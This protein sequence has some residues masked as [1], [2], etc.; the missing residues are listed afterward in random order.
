[1]TQ[2]AVKASSSSETRERILDAAELLFIER[3]FAATSLR[4]IASGAGVNLAAT[5]YH[6]GSKNGLL[7]AVFHRRIAPINEQR[8]SEFKQL[9]ETDPDLTIRKVVEV[10]FR[11]FMKSDLYAAIPA[12]IGRIYGEP[13]AIT[14]PLLESEFAEV[15]GVFHA[16][17]TTVLPRVSSKELQWRTH[18]MIGSLIHLLRLNSPLGVEPSRTSFIEGLEHLIN[19]SIAGLE[20][21]SGGNHDD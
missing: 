18:F 21:A 4:A 12:L 20:Q 1:M 13:E 3:G 10:F 19:F 11:P 7:A 15:A 5:H 9:T 16:A 6:F 14:K 17:A 8:L 2:H